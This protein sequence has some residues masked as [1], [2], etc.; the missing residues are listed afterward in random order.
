MKILL[1]GD[2]VGK[3]G[4]A[5]ACRLV[6]KLR[7]EHHCCFCI[8]NAENIA[9]GAGLTRAAVENL[10]NH[11]V[12]VVTAGDHVW[13]K[14]DYVGHIDGLPKALRPA[15]LSAR[16]PGRGYGIFKIPIGGTIAVIN[17]LGHVFMRA[18]VTC[19]FATVDRILEEIGSRTTVIIVDMH[20]EATSEKI[21]MGRHLDGRVTAVFGTHTHVPTADARVLPEGTAYITDLGMVGSRES[22]LGRDIKDVVHRFCTG[23][24]TRLRVVEDDIELH[25][26]VIE[27]DVATGKAL[28][29][30]SVS[31]V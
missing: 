26:A 24:P 18:Q 23:L 11:D 30:E 22:I 28:S 7:K 25:G 31:A 8:A 12:D 19:P 15:N 5:A 27:L 2:I 14:T 10:H 4:Q 6:P 13:D 9:G 1:V 16:Q 21:A 17:L 29:I 3:G 20:A